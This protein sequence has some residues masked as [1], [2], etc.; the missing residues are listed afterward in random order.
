MKLG[1]ER[2]RRVRD[3]RVGEELRGARPGRRRARPDPGQVVQAHLL[4]LDGLRRDA[5]VRREPALEP[6]GHVAQADR[7]MPGVQERL[8]DDPD[9]VRE[10]D[11]PRIR[12][13]VS[14]HLLREI[15]DHRH[16]A[17]RLREAA[18]AGRLLADGPELERQ[19]LVGLPRRLSAD[20]QL[21]EH[22]RGAV[23]RSGTVGRGD[24]TAAPALAAQDAAR[25]S[26]HHVES[27][28]VRIEQDELV[29]GRLA[30]PAA[31]PSTSSGV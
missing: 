3:R 13:G 15:Q 21:H 26:A 22:E 6:D 8:R 17:Q 7:P 5:P 11:Q 31:M 16:G 10:I 1:G 23:E 9:R 19:R 24:E 14:R 4:H 25:Q 18:G 29:D 27:R 20:A 2:G 30:A 12:G 28:L